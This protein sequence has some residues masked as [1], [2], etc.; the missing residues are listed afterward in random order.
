M[1][2]SYEDILTI[3]DVADILKVGTTQV[4]KIVRAGQLKAFKEGKDWKIAKQA[5]IEYVSTKSRL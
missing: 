3:Q 5:L 2:E 1:F 4:Y